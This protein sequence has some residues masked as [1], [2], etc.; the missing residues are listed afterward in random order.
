MSLLKIC[1]PCQTI[2]REIDYQEKNF[3]DTHDNIN[4]KM[5]Q[6]CKYISYDLVYNRES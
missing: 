5:V 1:I 4:T 3:K 2:E 6:E